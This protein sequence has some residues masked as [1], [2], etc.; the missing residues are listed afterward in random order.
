MKSTL[1]VA[2]LL[3]AALTGA[4]TLPASATK[5]VGS[6]IDSA[7]FNNAGDACTVWAE[8]FSENV[9]KMNSAKTK[10]AKATAR[11]NANYAINKGY[12]GGCLWVS[13]V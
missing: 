3:A 1:I 6:H 11:D 2:T 4:S 7:E 12:A 9:K 8:Y 5:N 13:A 10:E